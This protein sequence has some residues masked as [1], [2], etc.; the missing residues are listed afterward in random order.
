[1]FFDLD[2]EM[3]W[4]AH[5]GYNNNDGYLYIKTL[6]LV[7]LQQYNFVCLYLLKIFILIVKNIFCT[8]YNNSLK[9]LTRI[10]FYKNRLA[11]Y[12][13][14]YPVTITIDLYIIFLFG[15]KTLNG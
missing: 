9:T 8:Y 6:V 2:F 3:K 14:R 10:S 4:C 15:A 13:V 7:F 12:A 1:M 11:K 5:T